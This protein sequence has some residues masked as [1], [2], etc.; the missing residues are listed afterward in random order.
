MVEEVLPHLYRI[1]VPLPR[2]PLKVLNSYLIKDRDRNLLIDTGFNQE[3]CRRAMT[4]A[5]E[6]LDVDMNRTDLFITHLHSDHLGQAGILSKPGS[7]IY[8]NEKEADIISEGHE[9]FVAQWYQ[10]LHDAYSTNGFPEDELDKAMA[11][12]PGRRYEAKEKIDFTRVREGDIITAGDYSFR[13]IDTPGHSP[14]H[15]CLYEAD[16]KIFVSGD[17]ILF[18]ITPNIAYW[19]VMKDPLKDYLASLDK[20]FPLEAEV[21]LPGHRSILK[22]HRQRI[23][24]LK[25]H[26]RA[27]AEEAMTALAE[28][29]RNAYQVAPHITW[30]I[31]YR[32]WDAFPA[33]Q[34]WFAF[35]ETLAHLI[36]LEGLG[37]VHRVYRD[38]MTLFART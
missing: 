18:D 30:D 26:H 27:R 16:K 17:H 29:E 10:Q 34:K 11:K 19:S 4:S 13:C 7:R 23:R 37:K 12:H 21:V 22:D 38:G 1:E 35:G 3:E 36:Y 32:S 2:N 31:R 6:E 33:A 20:V 28:G 9:K 5:L 14:G 15:M 25:E 8:F 24:E